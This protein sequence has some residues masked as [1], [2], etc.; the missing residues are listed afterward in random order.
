MAR[1]AAKT[2]ETPPS[3]TNL[4]NS[5]TETVAKMAETGANYSARLREF[6]TAP[7][8]HKTL[9]L[10]GIEQAAH[11]AGCS[12]WKLRELV[13]KGE[14]SVESDPKGRKLF[15]LG[16]IN[17]AREIIGL[18]NKGAPTYPCR[19]ISVPNQK[20]GV[21]KSATSIH[22]AQYAAI[23]RGLRTL[24]IDAD[25]QATTTTMFG[26]VPDLDL[27]GADTILDALL[28][29]SARIT[30]VVRQTYIDGLDL[31][32]AELEL[33]AVDMLLPTQSHAEPAG[34]TPLRLRRALDRL[35]PHYDL[36]VI[37]PPPSVTML[38]INSIVA[39]DY[40]LVPVPPHMFEISSTIAF[41]RTISMILEKVQHLAALPRHMRL[42]VT[43]HDG[44]AQSEELE[45]TIRAM[46]PGMVLNNAM[47]VTD[48]ISKAGSDLKTVYEVDRPRGS[49]ATY[50]RAM[51]LLDAV[52]KEVIE[53][54]FPE[55][56]KP[57][58][59]R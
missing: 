44:H 59:A 53:W 55:L 17:K 11:M 3:T 37:D 25:P 38:A 4:A 57:P 13:G 1:T 39:S 35:R 31:I 6:A 9:R 33:Q 10:F 5:F 16:A 24:V 7:N 21:G 41:F 47:R 29:D 50:I 40:L 56:V 26:Y 48:E 46:F 43:K 2:T 19:V 36:I 12:D 28:E 32:P 49:R 23:H 14:V 51:G 27:R 22:L 18:R 45:R 20:G 34:P 15:T 42:L 30:D 8:Q 58:Q 52:N 54:A